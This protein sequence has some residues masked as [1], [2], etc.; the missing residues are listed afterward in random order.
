MSIKDCKFKGD[1]QIKHNA[2]KLFNINDFASPEKIPI[3]D[4]SEKKV[5]LFK[6]Y[7][8]SMTK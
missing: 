1:I 3:K 5:S 7:Y 4:P 6:E 8:F 2:I